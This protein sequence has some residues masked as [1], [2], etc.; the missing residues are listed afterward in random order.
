[1][2]EQEKQPMTESGNTVTEGNGTTTPL[3]SNASKIEYINSFITGHV[4]NY[5][6]NIPTNL[7][8]DVNGIKTTLA[9]EPDRIITP[10]R[11]RDEEV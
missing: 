1:M 2:N 9:N 5:Y 7:Q 10:A 6:L 8:L 3:A 11:T 4:P